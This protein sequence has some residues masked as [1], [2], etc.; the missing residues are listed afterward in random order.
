MVQKGDRACRSRELPFEL[1]IAANAHQAIVMVAA[2]GVAAMAVCVCL[3][4]MR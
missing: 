3:S 1:P 2:T 4:Q